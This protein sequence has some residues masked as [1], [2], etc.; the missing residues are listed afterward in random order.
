MKK[1]SVQFEVIVGTYEEFVLGYQFLLEDGIKG[2]LTQT[3]ATHSHRASVRAVASCGKLVV[4]GGADETINI[5]NMFTRKESGMLMEHNGTITSLSFTPDCSHVISAS[6]D[7]S[8]KIFRQGSWQLEKVWPKAHKGT[9]VTCL[10]VHPSGKMALSVGKDHTL[11]TWNLVKGRPAYTTNLYS[12][13]KQLE[14]VV[15]SPGG[16]LFAIPMDSKLE[17]SSTEKAG[18]LQTLELQSKVTASIFLSDEVVC[19]GEASGAVSAY[20]VEGSCLWSLSVEERVRGLAYLHSH[21]VV[22]TS[23]GKIRVYHAPVITELPQLAASA[24]TGCR[25]TCLT[26]FDY[27]SEVKVKKEP[28]D[29]DR[30]DEKSSPISK[31]IHN[32][33]RNLSGFEETS[34]LSQPDSPEKK[35]KRTDFEEVPV[36]DT[37]TT[38]KKS[39]SRTVTRNPCGQKWVVEDSKR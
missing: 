33:K 18:I 3:F 11:R 25:I 36:S 38:N 7:G 16:I 17:I 26:L 21:L 2:E 22:G 5:Y 9:P 13:C 30:I 15:W 39:K 27:K 29:E 8:I 37:R 4:S 20:S 23:G 31:S 19:V 10:A 24:D 34:V 6:E 12:R 32:K 28:S 1:G 35:K 14:N